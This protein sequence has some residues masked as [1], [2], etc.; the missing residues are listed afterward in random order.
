[1][2]GPRD[3]RPSSTPLLTFGLIADVHYADIDDGSNHQRTRRRFYRNS[4]DWVRTAVSDW[5]SDANAPL[6]FVLDLGDLIDG[7]NARRPGASRS[8]LATI[9]EAFDGAKVPVF[10]LWGNHDLYNFTR[11]EL[12]AMPK[13]NPFVVGNLKQPDGCGST[14]HATYFDLAP[15][16]GFRLVALDTYEISML[17]TSADC[18]SYREAERILRRENGNGDLNAPDGLGPDK[19][20]FVKFNG[21]VS[22]D[23]LR[24][25]DGVLTK[26]DEC[27][28]I[29]LVAGHC[30]L[31][32]YDAICVCWNHGEILDTL[33]R[34]RCALAYLAGHA[35]ERMYARDERG[36]HHFTVPGAIEVEPGTA[37]PGAHCTVAL[38][39]GRVVVTD[40]GAGIARELLFPGRV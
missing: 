29:V 19:R 27:G 15:C 21:A 16:P 12:F 35:H 39:D 36:L 40:V 8:A 5:T 11:K 9:T 17:G 4:L 22:D 24:W 37:A 10:H 33:H 20:Q 38:Y 18:E 34:H 6:S 25:L 32:S 28:E 7:Y 1:M 30:P 26:A 31:K 14:P 3:D 13:M 2:A 23:Q